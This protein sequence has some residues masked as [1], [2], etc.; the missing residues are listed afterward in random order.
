M[1]VVV[2]TCYN[3]VQPNVFE[4]ID[5]VQRRGRVG[6]LYKHLGFKHFNI[7]AICVLSVPYHN[8]CER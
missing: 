8:K 6:L 5:G 1:C 2:R 3:I 7:D 4:G